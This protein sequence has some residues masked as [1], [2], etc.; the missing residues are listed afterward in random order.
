[1]DIP[2]HLGEHA[3]ID[4]VE[5]AEDIYVL[6]RAGMRSDQSRVVLQ[7]RFIIGDADVASIVELRDIDV[8]FVLVRINDPLSREGCGAAVGM[9]N[10]DDI[11]DPE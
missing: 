1:M 10:H 2:H 6:W 3:G 4:V 11:L 7:R 5:V 8:V 9:V